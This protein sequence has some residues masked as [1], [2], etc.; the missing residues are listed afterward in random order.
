M[1]NRDK[2]PLLEEA[3]YNT[4]FKYFIVKYEIKLKDFYFIT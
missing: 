2:W 4:R 3:L 1:E